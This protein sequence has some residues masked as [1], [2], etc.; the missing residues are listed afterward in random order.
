MQLPL[1]AELSLERCPVV[2]GAFYRA[3]ALRRLQQL[4]SLDGELVT[5]KEKV[6]SLVMH[7]DDVASRR[8]V[9]A[10]VLPTLEFVNYL[11]VHTQ[12]WLAT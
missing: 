5:A 11:Y 9:A 4:R 6:K 7:G 2:A 3:R 10:A 12:Q 8:A 1:L